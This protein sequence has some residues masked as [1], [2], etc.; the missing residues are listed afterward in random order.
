[1]KI[2]DQVD[3]LWCFYGDGPFPGIEHEGGDS[4]TARHCD[5]L[6]LRRRQEDHVTGLLDICGG[7]GRHCDVSRHGAGVTVDVANHKTIQARLVDV[8]IYD[9]LL[10]EI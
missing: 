6:G 3:V 4:T 8:N 5:K 7:L 9:N 1:M 10:L 2:T